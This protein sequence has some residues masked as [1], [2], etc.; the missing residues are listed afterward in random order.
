MLLT[1]SQA[2][3]LLSLRVASS[4]PLPPEISLMDGSQAADF[5]H[6]AGFYAV[7]GVSD[8]PVV[9]ML[10]DLRRKA[11]MATA[12]SRAP[13]LERISH[14]NAWMSGETVKIFDLT[15]GGDDAS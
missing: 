11:A 14:L 6:W 4:I 9:E 1:D 5:H 15:G 2:D 12:V 10:T 13:Y 3:R 8:H 7:M